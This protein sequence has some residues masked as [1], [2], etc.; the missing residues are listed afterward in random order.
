VRAEFV[1]H[2]LFEALARQQPDP[3]AVRQLRPDDTPVIALLP[4]SRRHVIEAMLPRQLEVVRRL[5]DRG[6]K[7]R[8][9]VSCVSPERHEQIRGHLR[10]A[11]VKA[12]LVVGDN[13]S[14]LTA[15]EVVLVASGTAT[16]EVAHY[17]KPMVVMYD[18]GRLLAWPHR[19]FGRWMLTTPHLSLVNILAGARVVPEFMPFVRDARPIAQIVARLLSDADWRGLMVRQLDEVVRPLGASQASPRVCGMISELLG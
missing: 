17:R 2:P 12:A 1:G 9:A 14:L 16:L 5:R 7:L 3:A 10:A 8:A 6:L 18:A 11:G 19:L 13:A 4:G 15:A